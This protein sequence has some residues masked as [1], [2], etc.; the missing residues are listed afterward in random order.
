MAL[1]QLPIVVLASSPAQQSPLGTWQ[2]GQREHTMLVP[3]VLQSELTTALKG[4]KL[5]CTKDEK[6]NHITVRAAS[7]I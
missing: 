1:G 7:L 3:L 2:Q 5:K 6:V 4:E